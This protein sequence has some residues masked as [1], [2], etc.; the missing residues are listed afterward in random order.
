MNLAMNKS[1]LATQNLE[2]PLEESY[3]SDFERDVV[4]G[5][6]LSNKSIPSKYFY[7]KR[8]SELFEAITRLDEY[9]PTRT[10]ISILERNVFEIQKF[11]KGKFDLI[12]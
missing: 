5:L 6:S 1:S 10:E 11:I 4:K 9:Y 2:I 3:S 7:D 12:A 8:G